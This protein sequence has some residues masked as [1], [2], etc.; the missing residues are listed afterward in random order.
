MTDKYV[1]YINLI[2]L[3]HLIVVGTQSDIYFTE[4]TLSYSTGNTIFTNH[5]VDDAGLRHCF[6]LIEKLRAAIKM[7]ARHRVG[8]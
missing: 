5:M 1:P 6:Y 4:T 7:N 8:S 2:K 3:T